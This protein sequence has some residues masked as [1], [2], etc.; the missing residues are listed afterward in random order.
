MARIETN[1]V[2]GNGQRLRQP[3]FK[4]RGISA[5]D[6]AAAR[7]SAKRG[8]RISIRKLRALGSQEIDIRRAVIGPAVATEITPAQIIGK[9][10]DDVRSRCFEMRCRRVS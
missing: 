1:E 5:S 8:C 7:R 2:V 4:P 3:N 10:K 6:E 9:D